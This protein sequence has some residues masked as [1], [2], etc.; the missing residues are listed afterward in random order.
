LGTTV[1]ERIVDLADFDCEEL[2]QDEFPESCE[3][4]MIVIPTPVGG[5]TVRQGDEDCPADLRCF[6]CFEDC[7]G[8]VMRCSETDFFIECEDGIV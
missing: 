7:T 8:E 3:G 4:L 5:C 1:N 6:G 2:A